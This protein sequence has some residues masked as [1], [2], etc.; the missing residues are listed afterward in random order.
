MKIFEFKKD[1][2]TDHIRYELKLFSKCKEP[3]NYIF[4]TLED[5]GHSL[6]L[7][8]LDK[9]NLN[10]VKELEGKNYN[11]SVINYKNVKLL[12]R[13]YKQHLTIFTKITKPC[14]YDKGKII[15][16]FGAFTFR[17]D[18]EF[19]KGSNSEHDAVMDEF[20]ENPFA[21]LNK[22]AKQL[23]QVLIERGVYWVP[24]SACWKTPKYVQVKLAYEKESIHSL[25]NFVFC[26]EEIDFLYSQLFSE[27][28]MFKKLAELKNRIG[29]KFDHR[30]K[31]TKVV[32]TLKDE[33]YHGVG[34]WLEDKDKKET[35]KDVYS[36]T[37]WH[38]ENV[39]KEEI[40]MYKG[41]LYVEGS[42]FK[43]GDPVSYK[44]KTIEKVTLFQNT[45][46]KENFIPLKKY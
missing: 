29:E 4:K 2:V 36:L 46:P 10:K 40:Y 17:T 30:Y 34:L 44:D 24:N 33:Y 7:K 41:E 19:F 35:F 12:I 1:S 27:N 9:I 3:L 18:M 14:E 31:I 20:Y 39:F 23:F 28:T 21:D 43:V 11:W 45:F 8:S 37:S 26:M 22:C 13:T 5:N 6:I 42:K 16:E 32:T 38:F 15:D 25:D